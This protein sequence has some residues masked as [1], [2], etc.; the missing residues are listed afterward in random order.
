MDFFHGLAQSR[1]PPLAAVIFVVSAA[2]ASGR[3]VHCRNNAGDARVLQSSMNTG[4]TVILD[5]T[6]I[7]GATTLTFGSNL[8]IQ[9]SGSNSNTSGH[10]A[11]TNT[12]VNYTGAG[13]AF[14]SSGD[15]NT[16]NGLTI[17]G[18][19]IHLTKNDEANYSGQV[20]WSITN[21]TIENIVSEFGGGVIIE[22]VLGRGNP[23]SPNTISN[24]YF[25]NL[26]WPAYTSSANPC[27]KTP[28]NGNKNCSPPGIYWGRGIDN[29]TIDNNF[30]FQIGGNP[31]KGFDDWFAGHTKPY[32]ATKIVISNNDIQWYGRIAIENQG[33]VGNC[34]GGCDAGAHW[35]NGAVISGNFVHNMAA[36]PGGPGLDGQFAYSLF[37][38][39]NAKIINNTA[40]NAKTHPCGTSLSLA[41]EW[42]GFNG[43]V[44]QGNVAK[45]VSG[46]PT[47]EYCH[48]GWAK[49]V[50]TGFTSLANKFGIPA[51]TYATCTVNYAN[52]IYVNSSIPASDNW[53]INEGGHQT[54]CYGGGAGKSVSCDQVTYVHAADY[55]SDSTSAI[56]AI[57]ESSSLSAAF[58]S[59]D[60]QIFSKAGNI[61]WKL[62]VVSNLS[63]RGVTFC[64]DQCAAPIATQQ[65]QDVN[66]EFAKDRKWLYHVDLDISSLKPGTHIITAT[67]SDA[68]GSNQ[69]VTR[70]F[71]VGNR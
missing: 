38:A 71:V 34:P 43:S 54:Y 62:S 44:F 65:I 26:W 35:S 10:G 25:Y 3:T 55:Q 21:N 14:A 50:T 20:G 24:N 45:S 33:Q 64:L 30:F 53:G 70:Q 63:V 32:T 31:I 36:P 67:A 52:N 7:L 9:G 61:R 49:S 6:C 4:G 47:T 11:T 56:N 57:S 66:P 23:N 18:G 8:N 29:T 59:P 60:R 37:W 27:D 48:G 1:R 13:F 68:A 58:A 17:N 16:I 5:G 12:V 40:I 42:A 51:C 19:G 15:N 69:K 22:T 46:S 2:G 39:D 28:G 41:Y